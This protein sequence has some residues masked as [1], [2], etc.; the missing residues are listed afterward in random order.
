MRDKPKYPVR[1]GDRVAAVHWSEDR[2]TVNDNIT[3]P[4][5]TEGTVTYI[6]PFGTVFVDWDNGA[7][8][9]LLQQDEYRVAARAGL[10]KGTWEEA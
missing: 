2:S 5:G 9:G 1:V 10:V 3:V 4:P 7:M 6:D 8:L